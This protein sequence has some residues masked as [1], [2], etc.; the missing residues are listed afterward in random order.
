MIN[1]E[2]ELWKTEI[3][4]YCNALAESFTTELLTNHRD[5]SLGWLGTTLIAQSLKVKQIVLRESSNEIKLQTYG[6]LDDLSRNELLPTV[7][8]HLAQCTEDGRRHQLAGQDSCVEMN[9]I[10]E[11]AVVLEKRL[12]RGVTLKEIDIAV[13]WLTIGVAA[14]LVHWNE[15]IDTANAAI[16]QYIDRLELDDINCSH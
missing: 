4:D 16:M 10:S 13:A 8:R 15:P 2:Y 14:L 12:H 7:I 6:F 3:T 11:L 9:K 5:V 1:F